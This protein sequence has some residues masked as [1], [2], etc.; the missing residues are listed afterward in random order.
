MIP[1]AALGLLKSKAVMG[2]ALVG[3]ALLIGFLTGMK[4]AGWRHD[5]MMLAVEQETQRAYDEGFQKA[6]KASSKIRKLLDASKTGADK[7]Q[8]VWKARLDNA[9][10]ALALCGSEPPEGGPVESAETDR[11]VGGI[12]LSAH[13]VGLWN[14]A[15]KIGLSTGV[16]PGRADGADPGADRPDRFDTIDRPVKFGRAMTNHAENAAI[17][18][19]LRSRLVAWQALAAEYGWQVQ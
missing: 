5:S 13:A 12:Y 16:D 15:N 2:V 9:Q 7:A 1:L 11:P 8:R 6:L 17:C 3:G 4:V 14:D 18:N 19:S 10:G